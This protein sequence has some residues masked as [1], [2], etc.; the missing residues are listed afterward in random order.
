MF[1]VGEDAQQSPQGLIQ[2]KFDSKREILEAIAELDTALSE[3]AE[4][5]LEILQEDD[6]D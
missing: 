1:F 4:Q 3:D 5:A 6:Q 2:E